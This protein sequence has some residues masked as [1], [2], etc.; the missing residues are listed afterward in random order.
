M[1]NQTDMGGGSFFSQKHQA[2]ILTD[3]DL[4]MSI[5]SKSGSVRKIGRAHV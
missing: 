3:P 5:M 2:E 1:A 4:F